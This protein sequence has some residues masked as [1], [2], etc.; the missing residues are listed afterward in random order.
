M[1]EL[2]LKWISLNEEYDKIILAILGG[3]KDFDV[4]KV[5]KMQKELFE[6]EQEI[7]EK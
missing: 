6:L 5:K 4:T 3:E 2:K 1:E 7:L